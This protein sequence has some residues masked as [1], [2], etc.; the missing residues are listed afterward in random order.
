MVSPTAKRPGTVDC[1]H[2]STRMPPLIAWA[3]WVTSISGSAIATRGAGGRCW[4]RAGLAE[5]GSTR[6]KSTTTA[7]RAVPRP[8]RMARWMAMS[9]H[10]EW[11]RELKG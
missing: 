10:F 8:D 2:S 5:A 6:E 3:A 4:G 1:P 7:P 9:S 11:S